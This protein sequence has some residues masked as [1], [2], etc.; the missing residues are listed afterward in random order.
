MNNKEEILKK[1]WEL[2]ITQKDRFNDI[3]V[4]LVSNEGVS[5]LMT[6]ALWQH[7]FI[8]VIEY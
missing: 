7:L 6:W 3:E 1:E 8:P 4:E 5:E 2:G